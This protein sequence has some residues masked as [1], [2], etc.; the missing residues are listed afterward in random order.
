MQIFTIIKQFYTKV[1]MI[2]DIKFFPGG[3]A[4]ADGEVCFWEEKKSTVRLKGK[5]PGPKVPPISPS[6]LSPSIPDP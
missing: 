1:S 6:S 3:R 5:G 2:N 4:G